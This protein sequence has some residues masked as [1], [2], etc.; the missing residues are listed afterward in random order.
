MHG[1]LGELQ[2]RLSFPLHIKVAEDAAGVPAGQPRL[3]VPEVWKVG[4]RS[5]I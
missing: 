4:G 1:G 5:Y 2:P 3:G